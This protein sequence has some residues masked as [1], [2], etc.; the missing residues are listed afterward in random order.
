M[1][2]PFSGGNYGSGLSRSST[3]PDALVPQP[4]VDELIQV[5]PQYS[6]LLQLAQTRVMSALTDRQP[7][8]SALPI[9]TW[10]NSGST[11]GGLNHRPDSES[12]LC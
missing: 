11:P 8:L 12:L 3:Q 9:A 1:T 5:L 4:Y 7:V 6:V 2:S 10:T